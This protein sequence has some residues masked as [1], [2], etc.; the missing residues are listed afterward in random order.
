[1]ELTAA[2]IAEYLGGVVEGNLDASVSEFAKIEE[3]FPGALS[4]L[5]NPKYE[6]YLYTTQS[7]IVLINRDYELKAPVKP[8]LVRVDDSYG[9][10][11]KLL[12]YIASQAPRRQGVHSLAYIEDGA[13][14]G[15]GAY[16][17]P[18]VY[19]GA[20]AVVE[21]NAQIY[22]HCFIGDRARIGADALLYAGVKVYQDCEVGA[23]TIVHAGAVIGADGFG[24]APQPD[25]S[26]NKIP[27]LGNVVVGE[28]VEI[29]ANTTIDRAAMGATRI[30]NGVKLDNLVQIAHNVEIG[31]NTAVAA[32]TG[33]A[34]S[35]K[36]GKRCIFA[37]QVGVVGHIEIA[38]DVRIG[39][40]A[41]ISNSVRSANEPLM[42]SPSMPIRNFYKS[43]AYFRR[44]PEIVAEL[45]QLKKE[46]DSAT[47]PSEQ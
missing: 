42:G 28:D 27:Q 24:F 20:D 21:D 16:I 37:G 36:V 5:S 10:L 41:G 11:A 39:A 8:T 22:P 23:R 14:I 43:S 3:G 47:T 17:G 6:H 15:T 12:S 7:T 4:F 40:Q 32:Q 25:G 9:S 33:I 46:I 31:E 34:G 18:F 13:A 45:E 30:A 35:T 2:A 44:L 19:I 1:M 26:Y 29:G 38:D